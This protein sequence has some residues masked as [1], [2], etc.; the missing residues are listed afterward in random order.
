MVLGFP[1]KPVKN[2]M[3]FNNI[4]IPL[5]RGEFFENGLDN[6]IVRKHK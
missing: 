4:S 5:Q 2:T 1:I 3:I 6:L